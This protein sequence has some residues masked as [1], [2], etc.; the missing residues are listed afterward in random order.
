MSLKYSMIIR[1]SDEDQA[2]LVWLPEFGG[3]PRTH[4]ATYEEAARMGRELIESFVG[5]YAEDNRPL[6]APDVHAD[7]PDPVVTSAPAKASA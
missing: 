3:G 4:G 5:W 1:W 6:P 7:R 2:F